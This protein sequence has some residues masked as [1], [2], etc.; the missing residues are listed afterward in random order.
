MSIKPSGE[1]K[2]ILDHLGDGEN[3]GLPALRIGDNESMYSRNMDSRKYPSAA[4]RPPRSTYAAVNS[5]NAHSLGQRNNADLH[6]VDGNTWK[7]WVPASSAYT[8]LTTGLTATAYAEIGDFV[9]GTARYTILMNSTQKLIAQVGTS[10]AVVL[11]DANTP[12]TD[13]FTVHNGRVYALDGASID[14]C[15]LNKTSDWT[16]VDDSGSITVTDARGNGTA[17]TTYMDHVIV[18]TEYSMHELWGTGPFNYKLVDIEGNKGC[19]SHRSVVVANQR[20]YWLWFNEVCEYGGGGARKVSSQVDQYLRNINLTYKTK[21]VG[22]ATGDYYYLA[23]PYGSAATENNLLLKFDTRLRKWYVETGA[24]RDFV[25]I[26]DTLYGVDTAGQ[27]WNMRDMSAAEGSDSATAISWEL[28]LR[29]ETENM[30]E[31][32]TV[33]KMRLMADV[34]TG[35]TSF[36]LGYSTNTSNNDSTSF[37]ALKTLSG[38]SNTQSVIVNMPLDAVNQDSWYRLRFAGTGYAEIHMLQKEGRVNV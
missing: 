10:T 19:I 9:T 31:P 24:F 1:F 16:T 21:C 35:S 17:I 22:G 12:F 34:S 30:L 38:S 11:G 28:I 5:T 37:T 15:A 2:K 32:K 36:S 6:V 4:V 20:L 18:W 27:V 26:G 7:Y 8:N 23:I 25:T 3:T 13:K 33:S 29:P 14:Y